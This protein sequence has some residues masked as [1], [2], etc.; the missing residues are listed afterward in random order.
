MHKI[1]LTDNSEGT[2]ASNLNGHDPSGP[3]IK[4]SSFMAAGSI[5]AWRNLMVFKV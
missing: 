3:S 2:C 4:N 1:L 5:F